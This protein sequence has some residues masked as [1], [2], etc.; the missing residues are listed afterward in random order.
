MLITSFATAAEVVR[1]QRRTSRVL[2]QAGGRFGLL[3]VALVALMAA[4]P[5]ILA[6]LVSDAVLNSSPGPSWWRASTRPGPAG[7]R[8]WSGWPWPWRTS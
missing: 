6:S 5:L 8:W 1:T 2:G 7:S 4:A 3:L